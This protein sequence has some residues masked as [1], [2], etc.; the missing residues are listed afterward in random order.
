VNGLAG[1]TAIVTGGSRGIGL[2]IARLLV[3][4]GARVV[5]IA[6]ERTRLE[7]VAAEIGAEWQVADVTVASMVHQLAEALVARQ[8]GAPDIVVNSAGA[9]ELAPIVQTSVESFDRHVA[10]NLRAVFLLARAFL[11][12]M[13]ARGSGQ[14]VTIGSIAGRQAFAANGAYAASK[15]GVRGLHGVMQA[16][17]KGTGVRAMLIEPAATDTELWA[18][19]DRIQHPELPGPE[20]MLKAAT[21]AQAVLYA[22]LQPADVV[23]PNLL[24]ERA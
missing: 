1:R 2:E 3:A 11:P 20:D 23:V 8:G 6:R 16:E 7:R 21:V 5:L 10:V 15:F 17:L 12:A 13:L 22:L 19:V 9:F 14:I 4:D 24:V 18:A